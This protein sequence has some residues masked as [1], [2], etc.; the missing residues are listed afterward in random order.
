M[1]DLVEKVLALGSEILS[2]KENCKNVVN[3]IEEGIVPRVLILDY[4]NIEPHNKPKK[5]FDTAKLGIFGINPGHNLLFENLYYRSII[6]KFQ[7]KDEFNRRVFEEIHKTW[8]NLF[9]TQTQMEESKIAY[10]RNTKKF[11]TEI[12][13]LLGL[14]TGDPIIWA[15]IVYCERDRSNHDRSLPQETVSKCI[16]KF[17]EKVLGLINGPIIC[18]GREA[19]NVF[20]SLVKGNVIAKRRFLELEKML[21]NRKIIGIYHPSGRG[22]F[23]KYFDGKGDINNRKLKDKV[24]DRVKGILLSDDKFIEFVEFNGG[25]NHS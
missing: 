9:I 8:Q 20:V 1:P 10:F 16:G 13:E 23:Y 2:C 12:S 4:Y 7:G 17:M 15:E 14:N 24:K 21:E 6:E 3:N 18:L 25:E 19:Y 11:V 22:I 5:E